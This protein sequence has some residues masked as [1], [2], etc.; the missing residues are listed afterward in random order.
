MPHLRNE[1]FYEFPSQTNGSFGLALAHAWLAI[2][3]RV[4]KPHPVGQSAGKACW[5][6]LPSADKAM[7]KVAMHSLVGPHFVGNSLTLQS[8]NSGLEG[9]K[10]G[11]AD[12]AI[13]QLLLQTQLGGFERPLGA[14]PIHE[15]PI[16]SG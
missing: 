12:C 13:A 3:S 16:A 1:K 15:I 4:P 11:A 9:R 2:I 10:I 7:D 5:D 6:N 14:R 8:A